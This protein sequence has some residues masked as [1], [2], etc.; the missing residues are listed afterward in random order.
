MDH[1]A[2]R[3]GRALKLVGKNSMNLIERVH[4]FYSELFDIV[5]SELVNLGG[6]KTMI[7]SSVMS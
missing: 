4:F 5:D 6:S 2:S 1:S 7:Y 3:S